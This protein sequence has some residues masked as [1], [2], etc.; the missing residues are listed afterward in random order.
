MA[1]ATEDFKFFLID[2]GRSE[3]HRCQRGKCGGLRDLL[4]V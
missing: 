3:M 4:K 2:F 1:Q